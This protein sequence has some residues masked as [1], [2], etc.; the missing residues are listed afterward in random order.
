[1][2]DKFVTGIVGAGDQLNTSINDTC[3]QFVTSAIATGEGSENR[4]KNEWPNLSLGSTRPV[5]NL[6]LV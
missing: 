2:S 4:R 3:D 5:T 6:S 1:M